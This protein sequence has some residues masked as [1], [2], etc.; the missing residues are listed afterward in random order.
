MVEVKEPDCYQVPTSRDQQSGFFCHLAISPLEWKK[1][2][3][4]LGMISNLLRESTMS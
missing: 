3:L 1:T 2:P 4:A